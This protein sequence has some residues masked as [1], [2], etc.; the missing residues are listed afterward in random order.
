METPRAARHSR[1]QAEVHQRLRRAQPKRCQAI[2]AVMGRLKV[3]QRTD[4]CPVRD[5]RGDRPYAMPCA[6]E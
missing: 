4:R 1:W 3:N 6:T 5:G 2:E